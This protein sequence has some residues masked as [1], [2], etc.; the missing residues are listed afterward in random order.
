MLTKAKEHFTYPW[1]GVCTQP[2]IKLVSQEISVGRYSQSLYCL[3][4]RPSLKM[5]FIN[6]PKI[7]FK[8][9]GMRFP[10]SN[11]HQKL[12]WYTKERWLWVSLSLLA[13]VLLKPYEKKKNMYNIR[14]ATFYPFIYSTATIP[15][16]LFIFFIKFECFLFIIPKDNASFTR[17]FNLS[18]DALAWISNLHMEVS[19][20]VNDIYTPI[21][22][23]PSYTWAV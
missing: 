18:N 10:R 13:S 8:L 16:N 19:I 3:V 15:N 2:N 22:I 21:I 7:L 5:R 9:Q 1:D 20:F 11:F 12:V 17:G 23:H 4:S 6:I 14:K